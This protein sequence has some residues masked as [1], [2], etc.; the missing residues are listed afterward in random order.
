MTITVA[1]KRPPGPIRVRACDVRV[2]T[3]VK[4]DGLEI[5]LDLWVRFM[6]KSDTDLGVQGQKSLRGEG[7]GYGNEDTGQ[8]RR[9]NEIGE[10]TDAMIHSLR[11]HHQWAIRKI[12]GLASTWRFPQL[13][14]MTTAIDAKEELEKKLRINVATRTLF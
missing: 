2:D 11:V 4:P 8:A 5:C 6:Q 12:K 7:D 13:D 10:A 3:W 9:D 1:M 14:Y